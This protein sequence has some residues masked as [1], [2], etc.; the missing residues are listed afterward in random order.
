MGFWFI[1]IIGCASIGLLFA[2]YTVQAGLNHADRE[3]HDPLDPKCKL[4]NG[5]RAA[6]Y[7]NRVCKECSPVAEVVGSKDS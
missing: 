6:L 1:F 3:K 7:M 5:D 4:Y 2:I